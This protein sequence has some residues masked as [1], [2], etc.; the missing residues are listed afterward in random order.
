MKETPITFEPYQI[1]DFT[2]RVQKVNNWCGGSEIMIEM[3]DLDGCVSFGDTVR[4]ARSHLVESLQL[5]IKHYG[6]YSLPE[7]KEGAHIIYLDPP[8]EE[9]EF[10]YINLELKKL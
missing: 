1:S 5:W 10:N 6:D 4:E 2:W 8:M 3:V 7:I 9:S